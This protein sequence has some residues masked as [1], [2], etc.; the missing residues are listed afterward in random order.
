MSWQFEWRY[1][2]PGPGTADIEQ[3]WQTAWEKAPESNV[4]QQPLLSRIWVETVAR[5]RGEKPVL[6]IARKDRTTIYLPF[7]I[8]DYSW[9]RLWKR[10]L[11]ALGGGLVFDYQDPLLDGQPLSDEEW[12]NFWVNFYLNSKESGANIVHFLHLLMS[13]PLAER[14]RL[15]LEP[16]KCKVT[17][18]A[19]AIRMDQYDSF[20]ALLRSVQKRLREKVMQS[21]RI[22]S[23]QNVSLVRFSGENVRE[24]LS[25]FERM[26]RAY[27]LQH[28][29]GK[30]VHLFSDPLNI[31]FYRNL[32]RHGLKAGWLDMSC[33]MLG[34]ETVNWH[35][36]FIWKKRFYWYKPCYGTDR[37]HLSPGNLHIAYLLKEGFTEGWKLFDFTVGSEAYKLRWTSYAPEI[38]GISW[39]TDTVTSKVYK[40]VLRVA[41]HLAEE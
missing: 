32:I 39:Y 1:D 8:K 41:N 3:V 38:Y 19:P 15:R 2:W 33:L 18:V 16:V 9:N 21:M 5:Q 22:A 28:G 37:S 27:D 30:K 34:K 29:G 35:I 7:T 20:D 10:E 6:V 13:P 14:I 11:W 25:E 24:A 12:T 23:K 40:K 4:F 17:T 36:G 26:T 31:E